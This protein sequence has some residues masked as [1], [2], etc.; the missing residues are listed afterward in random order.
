VQ[1]KNL[2]C[3]TKIFASLHGLAKR[4]LIAFSINM[5][6][7]TQILQGCIISEPVENAIPHQKIA[8]VGTVFAHNP[9]Q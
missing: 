8:R 5:M 6:L 4:D 3:I 7:E 2:A 1:L 9:C